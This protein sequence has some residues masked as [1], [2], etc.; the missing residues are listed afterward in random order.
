MGGVFS[1]TTRGES[2]LA[3][4]DDEEARKAKVEKMQL[5]G[6]DDVRSVAGL[7]KVLEPVLEV[8]VFYIQS[9]FSLLYTVKVDADFRNRKSNITRP[10]RHRQGPKE[11]SKIIQSTS[12]LSVNAHAVSIDNEIILVHK[13]I[14]DH[15]AVRFPE[16]E[17]LVT[18]PLDYAKTVSIIGNDLDIKSSRPGMGIACVPFRWPY[19][20]DCYCRSYNHIWP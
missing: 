11:V 20:D 4:D 17:N 5:G 12:F 15:Y 19:L 1:G 16:L 10:Y 13:F 2:D 14:R 18:N 7:M 3:D 9:D 8:C 6:V